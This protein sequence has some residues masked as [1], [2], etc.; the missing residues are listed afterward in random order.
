[1]NLR[2]PFAIPPRRTLMLMLLLGATVWFAWSRW[3]EI[4][5]IAPVRAD[6]PAHESRT[7]PAAKPL[8][9]EVARLERPKT[10]EIGG[11]LFGQPKWLEP[12]P[13]PPVAVK[14]PPPPP[15]KPPELPFIYIGQMTDKGVLKVFLAAGS[16]TH[17]AKAGDTLR[18]TYVVESV[19]P[20]VVVFTYLPMKMQQTLSIAPAN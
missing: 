12:P 4:T 11:D 7:E 3:D 5:S 6:E 1:M 15:P 9:L 18:G 16:E 8:R 13:P 10:Q 19:S 14:P 17:T 2:L 20:E